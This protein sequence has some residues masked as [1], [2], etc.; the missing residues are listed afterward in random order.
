M[1]KDLDSLN[2]TSEEVHLFGGVYTQVTGY[3]MTRYNSSFATVNSQSIGQQTHAYTKTSANIRK[4]SFSSI[5]YAQASGLAIASS[6]RSHSTSNAKYTSF[7][8]FFFV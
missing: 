4:T 1:I 2:F 7:S 3:A 6:G 5:N 8:S